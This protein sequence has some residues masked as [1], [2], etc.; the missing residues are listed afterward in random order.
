[1]HPKIHAGILAKKTKQHIDELKK[2]KISTIDIVVINLYPFEQ[3]PSIENIDIGGVAMLRAA[4]KNFE[5]VLAV[6]DPTDYFHII[7]NIKSSKIDFSFRQKLAAKAFRHTAYYDSLIANYFTE[8]PFPE[9]ITVGLKKISDLRYGENPHQKA[10]IYQIQDVR[11]KKQ[12]L[13]QLQGKEL[14]YN[15]YLDVDSAY[16]LVCQFQKPS[17]VIV[18]HNNPCGVASAKNILDA[19]RNAL[20]CDPVSAFGGVL[21]FNK[22]VDDTTA[23]EV[24]KIFTEC[25]IAPNY[26]KDALKIFSQKQNLRVLIKPLTKKT[27]QSLEFRSISNGF[28]VQE[29]DSKIFDKLKIVTKTK[30]AKQQLESL[31]FAFTVAKYVK[32]NAIV[33]VRGTQTVGIGAGQMSRIDSLKIANIKMKSIHLPSPVSRLPLVLASDAFFPFR[34]VVN[35]S[36]KIGVKAIIQPGGSLKDNDSITA[37]NEHKISMVFTGMRHFRH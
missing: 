5:N 12:D 24:I 15:N 20:A 11:S 16:N 32:S 13:K 23:K 29:K 22:N 33:L 26:S 25:V 31:K 21:A 36:A 4:A 34:D 27:G 8:E 6:C 10:A 28:L 1:L 37:C 14:S 2:H 18:K 7:G 17:C 9:K 3:K 19:Y 30:P 35:E